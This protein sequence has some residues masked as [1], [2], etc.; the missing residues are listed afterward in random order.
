MDSSE[1]IAW[2][3]RL[4]AVQP[5]IRLLRSF[6]QRHHNYLGYVLR[7][8]GTRDDEAG[9][10]LVAV[11]KAA[12]AKHSFQVGMAVSGRSVPVADQRLR[13]GFCTAE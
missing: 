7:V 4:V 2:S 1:K 8:D 12:H 3:G 10:L 6:D 13:S 9:E 5:R 11:G